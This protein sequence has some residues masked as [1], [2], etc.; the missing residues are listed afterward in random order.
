MCAAGLTT[1]EREAVESGYKTG[2]LN[3]LMATSTLAVGVNL[4]A[5][6]VIIRDTL[7]GNVPVS[8]IA[9]Y[10]LVYRRRVMMVVVVPAV[11]CSALSANGWPC[12]QGP[13]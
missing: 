7:V 4:P 12:G 2:V 13:R 6:R 3:I 9:M 11:G 8:I 1:D 5:Q 10:T